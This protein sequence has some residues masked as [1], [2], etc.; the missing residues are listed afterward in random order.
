MRQARFLKAEEKAMR[1]PVLISIPLVACLLP[2]IVI[3]LL[4]PSAIDLIRTLG[5][6]LA[7]QNVGPP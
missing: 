6:A 2:V 3:V 4:L 1:I 5:P 7:H